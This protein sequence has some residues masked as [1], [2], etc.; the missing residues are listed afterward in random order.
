MELLKE[1][2]R[3]LK[4]ECVVYMAHYDHLG[5][6]DDGDV[7]N[8]ADD[9]GSGTV[10]LLEVAEAF[11]SLETKPKRSIVFLWVTSEELGMFGSNYYSQ[12]PVFPMERNGSL[13]QPRHGGPCL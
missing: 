5:V 2:T 12:H 6:A 8:G 7:Y 4:N 10:T 11:S 1:A 3:E 9:N 13:Y